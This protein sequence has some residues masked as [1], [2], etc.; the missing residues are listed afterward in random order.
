[1]LRKKSKLERYN[2]KVYMVV[3]TNSYSIRSYVD[4]NT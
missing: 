1:M 3:N 2:N 4:F